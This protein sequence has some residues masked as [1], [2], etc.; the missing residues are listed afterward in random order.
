MPE[1]RK[2]PTAEN[3]LFYTPRMEAQ[4]H[5]YRLEVRSDSPAW[6]RMKINLNIASFDAS[7]TQR[8]LLHTAPEHV[9]PAQS[10]A[11]ETTVPAACIT[12]S[13][14]A[15][16]HHYPDSPFVGDSP[17]FDMDYRIFRDDRPIAS[18][19]VPVNPW[20]GIQLIGLKYE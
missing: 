1:A 5:T 7:G 20:G 13:I 9:L 6:S 8:E 19:S 14:Y 15:V 3:S 11:L 18:A 10:I 16:P 2:R 12:V 17:E 4:M